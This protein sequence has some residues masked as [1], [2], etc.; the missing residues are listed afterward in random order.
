MGLVH[1][2]VIAVLDRIPEG[3]LDRDDIGIQSRR[4]LRHFRLLKQRL[5]P[6]FG[7]GGESAGRILLEVGREL[8][9]VLRILDRLPKASPNSAGSSACCSAGVE[10]AGI[11]VASVGRADS[12]SFERTRKAHRLRDV[13]HPLLAQIL[14]GKAAHLADVVTHAARN[15][16]TAGIGQRFEASGNIDTVAEYIVIL[17]HEFAD[18]DA[19]AEFQAMLGRLVLVLNS[20][21][22]LHLHGAIGR[23]DY[24]LELRQHD[25]AGSTS[26]AATMA[27]I[28]SSA[29]RRRPGGIVVLD[30]VNPLP[31]MLGWPPPR[32]GNLWSGPAAPLRPADEVFAEADHVL[33]PKFSTYGAW[34]EQARLEYSA[35]LSQNFPESEETQSW[36]VLSREGAVTPRPGVTKRAPHDLDRTKRISAPL[37]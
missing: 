15:A 32:G 35:Y 17:D 22:V 23:I 19:D 31:F 12:S 28:K 20:N 3:E 37:P 11:A 1:F 7:Q 13:F 27:A 33:I 25:I 26:D 4:L 18:I 21:S 2:R 8:G 24:T 34:T 6:G 10:T 29:M 14:E 5:A 16:N 36:I 9:R 30:Q